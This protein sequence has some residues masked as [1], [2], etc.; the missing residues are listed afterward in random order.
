MMPDVIVA[1]TVYVLESAY[2]VGRARVAELMESVLAFP[3]IGVADHE[4][5]LRAIEI[6]ERDRLHFA[7]AYL[8]AQAEVTGFRAVASFDRAI[9]RVG[10]IE[11]VEPGAATARGP[12]AQ[13][14]PGSRRAGG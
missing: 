12:S 9:D 7:E 5:V 4:L 8:V 2:R 10:G 14:A 1:E 6:Y 13:G 3:A 11:R